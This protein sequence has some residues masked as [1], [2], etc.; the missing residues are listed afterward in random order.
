LHPN[1][2][3]HPFTPT[4]RAAN[5]NYFGRLVMVT[6][7]ATFG[8]PSRSSKRFKLE[9]KMTLKPRFSILVS[10]LVKRH[11]EPYSPLEKI[12]NYHR[13]ERYTPKNI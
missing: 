5:S 3:H 1:H 4:I 9:F 2:H 11:I 7:A 8:H 13:S 6:R 10:A 12:V